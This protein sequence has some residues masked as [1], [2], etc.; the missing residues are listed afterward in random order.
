MVMAHVQLY[1]HEPIIIPTPNHIVVGTDTFVISEKSTISTTTPELKQLVDYFAEEI[2][3][4]ST[5]KDG[6]IVLVV[7]GNLKHEEYYL[8]VTADGVVISGGDYGG[9]FN[10]VATFLQL[11]PSCLYGGRLK[12]NVELV[13]SEEHT[14]ELQSHC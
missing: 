4:V 5:S 1:A 6:D 11:L 12:E 7:D 2:G 14:S 8:S 13:R 10:G 3:L 9:V